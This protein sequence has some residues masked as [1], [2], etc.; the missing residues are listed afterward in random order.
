MDCQSIKKKW[1]L[2]IDDR[3][4]VINVDVKNFISKYN[5]S[6]INES[7]LNEIEK[8]IFILLKNVGCFSDDIV[9][10]KNKDYA[11]FIFKKRLFTQRTLKHLR[12][13]K[14]LFS[15][16][17]LVL[18]TPLI[19]TNIIYSCFVHNINNSNQDLLLTFILLMISGIFH[20]IG[21]ISASIKFGIIPKWAGV[22]IYFTSFVFFVDVNDTWKLSQKQRLVVDISGIYF[23]LISSSLYFIIYFLLN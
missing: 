2:E 6:S 14:C 9:T 20:E 15:K 5:D 8:Q 19:V 3:K 17:A 4:F 12:I 21:H 13:F 10:S 1:I 11:R 23:Q 16:F 22:G 18:T 7:E